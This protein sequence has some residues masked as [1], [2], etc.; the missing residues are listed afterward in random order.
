MLYYRQDLD[1]AEDDEDGM[2]MGLD[3]IKM[4]G[5]NR[6][7][8]LWKAVCRRLAS[9][10]AGTAMDPYERAL[11]GSLAGH[12]QSVLAVSSK[13]SWEEH[14][15]AHVNAALEGRIEGALEG[16]GS[17]SVEG[18]DGVDG[19]AAAGG[20]WSQEA[21]GDGAV[22][23]VELKGE[24]PT[25]SGSTSANSRGS[26][27]AED[28]RRELREIFD[29]LNSS[30]TSSSSQTIRSQSDDPYRVLQ[31]ALILDELPTLLAHV[32]SRL[33][34]MRASVEP[35][36]YAHLVRFFAHVVLYLR[37]IDAP[38]LPGASCNGIL[39]YYVEVL[40]FVAQ[41]DGPSLTDENPS[42][43]PPGTTGSGSG[44]DLVAMY[45]SSLDPESAEA[46]YAHY[47]K[48]LNETAS[49]DEKRQALLR[50]REHHLDVAAVARLV[51]AEVFDERWPG[52]EAAGTDGRGGA[53][54]EGLLALPSATAGDA[55]VTPNEARL[56]ASLD[57]LILLP[58]TR[59]YDAVLQSNA[60][61]RALLC[62][63][64]VQAAR[65][66]LL[67]LPEDLLAAG[68]EGGDDEEEENEE[69]DDMA[70]D[71]QSRH[72]GPPHLPQ[73]ARTEHLHYVAFFSCLSSQWTL[74][75]VLSR[76][77]S[78]QAHL[79]QRGHVGPSSM[80]LHTWRT[81]VRG[82]VER[83][84]RDGVEDVLRGDWL[85]IEGEEEDEDEDGGEDGGDED[86]EEQARR[87]V[88]LA[89]I[90]QLYIPEIVVRLHFLVLDAYRALNASA[91]TT[92][93]QARAAVLGQA[94]PLLELVTTT[95]P[96]LV[97]DERYK[98]YLEFVAAGSAANEAEGVGG[99]GSGS[100]RL[101]EYL[102][103]VKDAHLLRL[104]VVQQGGAGVVRGV[105]GGEEWEVTGET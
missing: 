92:E 55:R 22:K 2:G 1:S 72:R 53:G 84:W 43:R 60:L 89:A 21:G 86:E 57:W 27:S 23:V 44:G 41:E 36:R 4:V 26:S 39:R 82:S 100:K 70:D 101:K 67:R 76:Q 69:Q 102:G 99:S 56:I 93:G 50:A 20:W 97:A 77:Q 10:H 40:E 11:Y 13:E 16:E 5:G 54:A 25:S 7:R 88:E 24:A 49:L 45:A 14:L 6:N 32:E 65:E 90:R 66:L 87:Q 58:K 29:R 12:L 105:V 42:S 51:V 74:L 3:G 19:A 52:L 18:Q 63:G 64:R 15:W 83:L 35:K 103:H 81:A 95:L 17:S 96:V 9:S 47:L 48:S 75:E 104:E 79:Q 78:H 30:T 8:L 98:V 85:K 28:V 46:S 71:Q 37:L 68:Q 33:P 73:N 59:R 62:R 38:G 80:E 31:Q 61:M 91:P 34:S 94:G